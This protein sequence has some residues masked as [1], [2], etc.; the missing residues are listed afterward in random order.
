MRKRLP[1]TILLI[2]LVGGGYYLYRFGFRKPSWG[3]L[4]NTTIDDP[5][6]TEKVKTALGLSKHL[7]GAQVNVQTEG[8]VVTLSGEVQSEESKDVAGSI[9]RDTMGVKDVKNLLI[10]NPQA[11]AS[12][13]GSRVRDIDI[14]ADVLQ[15][16]VK[17]PSLSGKKIDVKVDNQVVTLSG[18]VDT[19]ANKA[20]AEQLARS[21]EGVNGVTNNLAV[22]NP[23]APTEP[24]A[25][26]Q[27]PADPNTDLAKRV[28]F[29]LFRSGSFNLST[30]KVSA[31]N[32]AVTLAGTVRS[33]AEDLL[34]QRIAQGVDG[35]KTV[36]DN[37]KVEQ[38]K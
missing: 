14:R 37:L 31:N 38:E 10:V 25:A 24:P 22:A 11:N 32:G 9:A 23:Q 21:I 36:A 13:E 8:G 3:M 1:V 12:T 34:A 17:S 7:A 30:M 35:V 18:S 19:P 5:T 33:K 20:G 29:E 27:T 16:I 15:A 6:V 28:E 2:L 4:T 26:S